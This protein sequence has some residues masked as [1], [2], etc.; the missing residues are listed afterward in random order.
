M[1][2]MKG[3]IKSIYTPIYDI[4]LYELLKTYA[5][6]NMQKSFQRVNIP[7]LPVLTTEQGILNIKK[8][9]GELN[10]WTDIKEL[11]PDNLKT[12]LNKKKTGLSGIFAASLELTKEGLI[13]IFQ[14]KIFDKIMIK[15]SK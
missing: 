9:I 14:E 13:K 5:Y 4:S 7:K 3:G 15:K 1:R 6:I 11:I 8:K 10:D 2:G 12:D